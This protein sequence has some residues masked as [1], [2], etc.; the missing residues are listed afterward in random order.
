[1]DD[2]DFDS[3]GS[4]REILNISPQIG[5]EERKRPGTLPGWGQRKR[6]GKQKCWRSLEM[7]RERTQ[8][9]MRH[10]RDLNSKSIQVRGSNHEDQKGEVFGREMLARM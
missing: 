10:K 2:W 5:A 1:M 3:S 6:K 9:K 4:R 8:A 7:R